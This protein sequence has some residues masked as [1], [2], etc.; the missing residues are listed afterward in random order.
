M[1]LVNPSSFAPAIAPYSQAAVAG[2]YAFLAGQVAL[3]GSNQVVAPGDVFEQTR[4]CIRRIRTILEEIG[5][6]L[7]DVVTATVYLTDVTD[8]A[9]FNKAWA[10]AFGDHRPARAAVKAELLL[11]GLVVE[12]QVIAARNHEADQ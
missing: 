9:N 11:D 8:F 10:E 2:P 6:A 4:V 5:L 1:R 12:I 3:D 7:T